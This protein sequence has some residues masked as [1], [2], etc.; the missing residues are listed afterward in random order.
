MNKYSYIALIAA[1]IIGLLIGSFFQYNRSS[2]ELKHLKK[3]HEIVL[4]KQIKEDKQSIDSLNSILSSKDSILQNDA[5]AIEDL[6]EDVKARNKVIIKQREQAKKLTNKEKETW[7]T[8][9]YDSI[10]LPVS[11]DSVIISDPVA[12][13]VIDELIVKDGLVYEVGKQDSIITTLEH[14]KTALEIK[15]A[16]HEEK[17]VKQTSVIL[18][19]D[20]LNKNLQQDNKGLEKDLRKQKLKIAGLKILA[21]LE[22]VLIVLVAI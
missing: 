7:I 1:V 16:I 5:L 20:E 11:K 4:R 14:S 3:Q 8:S 17:D 21:V 9:R 18:K 13:Q 15:V 22:A 12:G 2:N 6:K 10:N 19:Q